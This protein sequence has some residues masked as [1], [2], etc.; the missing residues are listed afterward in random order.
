MSQF[1]CKEELY[2]ILCSSHEEFDL[3]HTAL[4]LAEIWSSEVDVDEDLFRINLLADGVAHRLSDEDNALFDVNVLS[5]YLF[6]E[7]GF[8]DRQ[9]NLIYGDEDE[10]VYYNPYAESFHNLVKNLSIKGLQS[11]VLNTKEHDINVEF[12]KEKIIN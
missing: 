9:H 10:V 3:A 12:L 2:K 5:E 11:F 4:L 6:D 1:K 8:Q 7:K